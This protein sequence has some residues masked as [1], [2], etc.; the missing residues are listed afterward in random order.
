MPRRFIDTT[1]PGGADDW[2]TYGDASAG[3]EAVLRISDDTTYIGSNILSQ[4]SGFYCS[5]INGPV[6]GSIMGLTLHYRIRRSEPSTGGSVDLQIIQKGSIVHKVKTL[7]II[8]TDWEDGE[9]RI[10]EDWVTAKRFTSDDLVNMGVGVQI[11]SVPS[12]GS[13]DVSK[14]WLEVEYINGPYR[15][16]PY[17]GVL[18]D[19]I[20]GPLLWGT[21]GTQPVALV[22]DYLEITDLSN[23]DTRFYAFID[24]SVGDIREG[25]I[26][27]IETRSTVVILDPNPNC[28]DAMVIGCM[29]LQQLLLVHTFRHNNIQYVG[30]L[31]NGKNAEDINQYYAYAPLEYNKKDIHYRLKIRRYINEPQKGRVQLFINYGNTP[32]LDI[33]YSTILASGIG[34]A[35]YL[36]GTTDVARIGQYKLDYFSWCLYKDGGGL[37]AKNWTAFDQNVN[38]IKLDEGDSD[39]NKL[40]KIPLAGVTAGQSNYACKFAINDWT[41]DCHIS[42]LFADSKGNPITYSLDLDYKDDAEIAVTGE[43]IVQRCSDLW[44]WDNVGKA[45]VSGF[46]SVTFP[47]STPRTKLSAIVSKIANA[48]AEDLLF[49]INRNSSA[50]KVYNLW[51]YK[52]RL[53]R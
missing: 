53:Y 14:L 19:T 4:K 29:D 47:S 8:S 37:S 23:T 10:R 5:S 31:E 27:E 45:W 48:K 22:S 20:I 17:F 21:F 2:M 18:P 34:N 1:A 43:I 39:I 11:N 33:P 35:W 38:M 25:Y 30:L 44:Y 3:W 7:S 26:T 51:L 52:V 9:I 13:F 24:S 12:S 41:E 6:G 32:L 16:D 49:T 40:K 36:F 46:T 42:Q 50:G 15:Y 28:A